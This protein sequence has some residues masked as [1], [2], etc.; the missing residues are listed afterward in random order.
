MILA[1]GKLH[2]KMTLLV[3]M[4]ETSVLCQWNRKTLFAQP[5]T[6]HFFLTL[7]NLRFLYRDALYNQQK[8]DWKLTVAW[9][10]N[11]LLPNSDLN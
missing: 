1:T 4:P 9:I 7:M 11:S 8:Q 2:A 10:M 3:S 6:H 5:K